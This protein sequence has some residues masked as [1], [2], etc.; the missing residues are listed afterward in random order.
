MPDLISILPESVAN[1][2]AAGE[3][4]QRPASVVKEL[5]ENA[6]DAGSTKIQ[7]LIREGGKSFIQVI[8]NGK[9]M[10]ETDARMCLERHATSKIR[11][12]DDLFNIR[13][14]GFRG[15]A[16]ASIGAVGH[17]SIRTKRDEDETGT[18]VIAENS[19]VVSQEQV[20]CA[21]GTTVTVKNI[22]FS[23]P[24]RKKFLK[25]DTI[26]L[27]HI[28]DEF[29]HVAMAH[30]EISFKL[31]H[32]DRPLYHLEK[33]SLR[34]RIVHI[35][36]TSI[37]ERIVPVEEDTQLVKICGFSCKP[38][39]ARKNRSDQYF[40]VNRRFIRSPYLHHAVM[41]VYEN[42]LPA[43]S[44][45]FYFIFL[46]VNPAS[47]DVNIHPTKTEIKF[48]NEKAI[49]S[50]VAAAV[51]RALGMFNLVPSIDFN[52][53]DNFVLQTTPS[54]QAGNPVTGTPFRDIKLHDLENIR[55]WENVFGKIPNVKDRT[56]NVPG[57]IPD[58]TVLTDKSDYKTNLPL[59]DPAI[60][61]NQ[62]LC[63][64]NKYIIT[65]VK[66][67]L[68]IID[69]VHA[70]ERIMY[71]RF[72]SSLEKSPGASQQVIFQQ[73]LDL[74]P[75][76]AMIL[77]GILSEVRGMGFDIQPIGKF[78]YVIDGLPAGFPVGNP[79]EVLEGFIEQV[80]ISGAELKMKPKEKLAM[81]MAKTVSAR[82]MNE[83]SQSE[84]ESLIN[85]LFTCQ[86]PYYTPSGKPVVTIMA[87]QE[88]KNRF[89]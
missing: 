59:T 76:D 72:L 7:I 12:A 36:G 68:M 46:E 1:K 53:E 86:I 87:G 24:A 60:N 58:A 13:S 70:N 25:N 69:R 11:T 3:V 10:S 39:F 57:E 16:L 79:I 27:R 56:V 34:Q 47:V 81:L 26:E 48:D 23:V 4:V 55:N 64:E 30:P 9:G 78:S 62:F 18:E 83:P 54:R 80:R 32:N 85:N 63:F 51:K 19:K 37:N 82:N 61:S 2:I 77:S 89:S 6:V 15:E 31:L 45:I 40:F 66:S 49:Y 5:L 52:P 73:V 43:G 21:T 65:K 8:D 33:S 44:H 71:E 35:C 67:G 20:S 88:I 28:N 84:M 22:F 75:G 38:E 17:T 74:S 29:L 50:I 14:F 41:S 42:L